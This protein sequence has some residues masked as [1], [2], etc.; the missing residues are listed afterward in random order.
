MIPHTDSDTTAD[1]SFE[2]ATGA[3][4][5]T[6]DWKAD[7]PLWIRRVD[8]LEAVPEVDTPESAS[9]FEAVGPEALDALFAPA[10]DS[11]SRSAGIVVVPVAGFLVTVWANGTVRIRQPEEPHVD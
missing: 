2:P 4:T 6:H 9:L 11:R 3:Y 5:F 1:P 10:R 7:G 8:A